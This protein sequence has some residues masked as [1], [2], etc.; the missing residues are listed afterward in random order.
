M[1]A[2]RQA[3]SGR[4]CP[5]TGYAPTAVLAKTI[6]SSSQAQKARPSTQPHLK[7]RKLNTL[8]PTARATLSSLAV[9]SQVMV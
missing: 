5:M 7:M 3:P 4:T 6:L 9:V 8:R 2:S 1:T